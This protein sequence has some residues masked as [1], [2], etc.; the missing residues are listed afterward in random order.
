MTT[1]AEN[2]ALARARRAE[3]K[4][5]QGDTPKQPSV[6]RARCLKAYLYDHH[7]LGLNVGAIDAHQAEGRRAAKAD[8]RRLKESL[9]LPGAIKQICFNCAGGQDSVTL[10]GE[11]SAGGDVGAKLRV[12]DC[13][14]HQCPLHPARPWKTL[15]DRKLPATEIEAAD[16][17]GQP[18]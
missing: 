8:Y 10:T 17:P 7:G 6:S 1:K 12:R 15:K 11:K 2:L 14:I 5:Q 13:P 18:V 3:L 9:G 16:T 4:A